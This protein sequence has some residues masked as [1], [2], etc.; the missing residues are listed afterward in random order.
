MIFGFQKPNTNFRDPVHHFVSMYN[1]QLV[2]W[3]VLQKNLCVCLTQYGY[4][5]S[6][7]CAEKN[8]I[9][10]T[11]FTISLPQNLEYIWLYIFTYKNFL[12]TWFSRI[13]RHIFFFAVLILPQLTFHTIYP[14]IPFEFPPSFSIYEMKSHFSRLFFVKLFLHLLFLEHLILFTRYIDSKISILFLFRNS[15]CISKY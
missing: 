11:I 14:Y 8:S 13:F 10:H 12:L 9:E 1:V 15:I 2:Y 3:I 7:L 6:I 5:L 4:S